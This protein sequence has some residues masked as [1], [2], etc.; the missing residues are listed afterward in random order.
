MPRRRR[1]TTTL[2]IPQV[3]LV[4]EQET[5]WSYVVPGINAQMKAKL[6]EHRIPFNNWAQAILINGRKN[7]E[8]AASVLGARIKG[9]RM[10]HAN[11]GEVLLDFHVDGS[12]D[13]RTIDWTRLFNGGA[14]I[15]Q[16]DSETPESAHIPE[17]RRKERL[18]NY[19]EKTLADA[20]REND[21]NRQAY[22]ESQRLYVEA[23]RSRIEQ[24]KEEARAL[25]CSCP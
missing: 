1:N 9:V 19:Q 15:S 18:R 21:P 20:N 16:S 17:D 14:R 3:D 7:L 25:R 23:C 24:V 10:T 5:H 11:F 13:F 8:R 4:R 6:E 12:T 2:H 22:L